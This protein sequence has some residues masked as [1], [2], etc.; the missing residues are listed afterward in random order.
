LSSIKCEEKFNE[1]MGRHC[2]WEQIVKQLNVVFSPLE[3][4]LDEFEADVRALRAGFARTQQG[5]SLGV[6][7]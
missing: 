2:L 3:T 5:V 6:D 7:R 1:M 4:K